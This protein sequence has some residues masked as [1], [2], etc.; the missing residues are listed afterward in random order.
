MQPANRGSGKLKNLN[1]QLE[2]HEDIAATHELFKY[3]DDI[4]RDMLLAGQY[5]L[6][7]DE[8]LNVIE[9]Y[10]IRKDDLQILKDSGCISIDQSNGMVTWNEDKK[11]YEDTQ[12]DEVRRLALNHNL[13]CVHDKMLVWRFPPDIFQY[14]ESVYILTYLFEGSIMKYY[15]DFYDIPYIK[16][17]VY[18]ED[19]K[20]ILGPYHPAQTAKYRKLIHIYDGKLNDNFTQVKDSCLSSS[21]M[22]DAA[23]KSSKH[24]KDLMQIKNNVG[25]FFRHICKAERNSILWTTLKSVRNQ[26]S[27]KG[28]TKAFLACNCRATNEFAY[29]SNL[30]YVLNWYVHPAIIGFLSRKNVKVDQDKVALAEMLQWIWRSQIR[31]AQPINVYIPSKRMR[32][33]LLEWLYGSNCDFKG[34]KI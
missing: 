23:K 33:L 28:Y 17:S 26:L 9:Q 21:W 25:N 3:L 14:F 10:D 29:A 2:R 19:D 24:H 20:W 32:R 15:F 30:A 34:R 7:L 5:T 16:K 6:I 18:K 12:F 11:N 1:E 4:S 13:I 31:C 22:R 8:V 27:G